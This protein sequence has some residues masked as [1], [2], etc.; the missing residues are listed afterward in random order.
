MKKDAFY[1]VVRSKFG[2]LKTHQV[3]GFEVILAA[4]D[5]LPRSHRA[6]LLATA[7]HETGAT[8][9]PLKETERAGIK[10]TDAQVVNI[11]DS[12]WKAGRLGQVKI[13]YWRFDDSGKSWFGRGYVQLTHRTNYAKA[14]AITGVDLLGD[15][16]RAMRPEVAAEVL[17]SGSEIGMFTG[18][19]LRDFLPGDYV[20]ARKVINGTDKATL[21]AGYAEVFERALQAAGV[22]EKPE[23]WRPAAGKPAAAAAPK[24][25]VEREK[26]PTPTAISIIGIISAALAY[27][28]SEVE[29]WFTNLFG[30]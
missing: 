9:Q 28:W 2:R 5:G 3:E 12:A 20:G 8:M 10:R 19:K 6:Y 30:G 18:R 23:V 27:W 16:S 11:L 4:I 26:N 15:P 1:T 13:P 14:S 22:S 7:W 17:V 24:P 21:I 25:A 29:M